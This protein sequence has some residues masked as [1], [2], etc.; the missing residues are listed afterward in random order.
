MDLGTESLFSV[1]SIS[2]RGNL[3]LNRKFNIFNIFMK[4]TFFFSIKKA[5][6]DYIVHDQLISLNN[7][8]ELLALFRK[9]G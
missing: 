9:I 1:N 6:T 5:F 8:F 4:N 2:D 7:S 3:L